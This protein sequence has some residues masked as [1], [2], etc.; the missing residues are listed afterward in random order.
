MW[1]VMRFRGF[2]LSWH[3]VNAAIKATICT[4]R[5]LS[6]PATSV[7]R[8]DHIRSPRSIVPRRLC[9]ALVRSSVCQSSFQLSEV[10]AL[11]LLCYSALINRPHDLVSYRCLIGQMIIP[12]TSP[13]SEFFLKLRCRHEFNSC[14][15]LSITSFID[16]VSDQR[17]PHAESHAIET[18]AWGPPVN[19]FPLPVDRP[20]LL[21]GLVQVRG[22]GCHNPVGHTSDIDFLAL[23]HHHVL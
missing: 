9:P 7:S 20:L 23:Q 11:R 10:S 19:A 4:R 18:C 8:H 14:F 17:Y 16:V 5:T 1:R 3:R 21:Q 22:A 15:Y 13:N 6:S 12:R 2:N